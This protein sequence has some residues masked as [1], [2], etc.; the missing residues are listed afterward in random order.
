MIIWPKL[1]FIYILLLIC[2]WKFIYI[3]IYVLNYLFKQHI[4]LIS[5]DCLPNKKLNKYARPIYLIKNWIS[6]NK[7]HLF[8]KLLS[9]LAGLNIW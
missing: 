9:K 8:N 4:Y 7:A 5:Q 6:K 2:M 3:I 1:I